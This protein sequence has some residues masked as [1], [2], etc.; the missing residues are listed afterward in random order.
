[1]ENIGKHPDCNLGTPKYLQSNYTSSQK[2][3]LIKMSEWVGWF[4]GML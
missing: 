4:G 1:M 3:T 2:S